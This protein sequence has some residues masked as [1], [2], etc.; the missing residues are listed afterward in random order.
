MTVK[1]DDFVYAKLSQYRGMGNF[2]K[3]DECTDKA[4]FNLGSMK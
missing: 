1:R 3:P 2:S 4:I